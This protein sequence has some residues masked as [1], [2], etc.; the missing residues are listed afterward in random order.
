MWESLFLLSWKILVHAFGI[1]V[2]YKGFLEYNHCVIWDFQK[3]GEQIIAGDPLIS[4]R[5]CSC[6]SSFSQSR[7]KTKTNNYLVKSMPGSE[8]MELVLMKWNIFLGGRK[9]TLNNY[10]LRGNTYVSFLR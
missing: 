5:I 3:E 7:N 10:L 4:T 2:F 9:G 6:W 8:Q 1:L